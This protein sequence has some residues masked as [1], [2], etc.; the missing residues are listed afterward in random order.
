MKGR[1][2]SSNTVSKIFRKVFFIKRIE[3]RHGNKV[4]T[5]IESLTFMRNFPLQNLIFQK[6]T[7]RM[8]ISASDDIC[9]K[10]GENWC[11]FHGNKNSVFKSEIAAAGCYFWQEEFAFNLYTCHLHVKTKYVIDTENSP[12]KKRR[13]LIFTIDPL[14]CQRATSH[15][16]DP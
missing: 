9:S 5:N 4:A 15:I 6:C 2:K 13:Q 12:L 14:F 1:Y 16:L 3:L 8:M 11:I 10:K 7:F